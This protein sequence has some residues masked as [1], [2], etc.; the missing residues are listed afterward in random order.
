MPPAV[1]L[2]DVV[3]AVEFCDAKAA[4]YFDPTN[5]RIVTPAQGPDEGGEPAGPKL[6]PIPPGFLPL[7]AFTGPD[8]IELARKFAAT[9]LQAENRQRLELALAG[10]NPLAGFETALFRGRIANE[11]FQFRDQRLLELAKDWLDTHG[12]PYVDDVIRATD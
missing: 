3:A 9:V 2:S 7:P 10:A 11:W 8:E 1:S 4:A 12:I 6:E 5:G